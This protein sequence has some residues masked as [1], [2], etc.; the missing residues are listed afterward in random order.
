M[1]TVYDGIDAEHGGV[2]RAAAGVLRGDGAAG[3][4]RAGQPLAEG[5]AA[6]RS[7]SS[8]RTRSPISTSRE[9]AWRPSRTCG[10][11]AGSA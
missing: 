3:R 10:R 5:H 9:A 7:G 4:G 8:T 6:A 2:D 11:T 1:A